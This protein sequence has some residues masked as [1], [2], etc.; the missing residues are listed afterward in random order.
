MIAMNMGLPDTTQFPHRVACLGANILHTDRNPD[1]P[2]HPYGEERD[3][4]DATQM[5]AEL[6]NG[7]MI[8]LIGST[9]NELGPEDL[10]RGNKANY[11]SAAA[12]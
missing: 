11:S 7:A 3:V 10:I 8:Y 5:I 12:R 6:P 4:A 1:D 2:A 9:V